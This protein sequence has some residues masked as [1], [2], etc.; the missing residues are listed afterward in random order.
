MTHSDLFTIGQPPTRTADVHEPETSRPEPPARSTSA[1]LC[2]LARAAA[3]SRGVTLVE[4][5]IVVAIMALI[6]GGVSF[7]VLPKYR[8]AQVSTADTTARTIRQAAN[9]WRSLKGGADECPTVSRLIEDKEIDPSS[10]TEDPWGSPFE[11]SC[12]E[13]DVTVS[14]PGPDGKQGT[15]D[16]VVIGPGAGEGAGEE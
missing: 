15:P 8:E 1:E 12:T 7:L 10:T 3:R 6:A 9:L 11:I 5:L 4:V 13:D 14:S 16:D 2:A